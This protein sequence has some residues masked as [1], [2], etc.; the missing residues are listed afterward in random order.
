MLERETETDRE[1]GRGVAEGVGGGGDFK[2]SILLPRLKITPLQ[3]LLL[4]CLTD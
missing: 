4:A 2:R 3:G 1:K